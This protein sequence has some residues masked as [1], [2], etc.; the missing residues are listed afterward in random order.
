MSAAKPTA[1]DILPS[2]PL[3]PRLQF[4][5]IFLFIGTN[6]DILIVWLFANWRSEF[7]G[8]CLS[9]VVIAN[10]SQYPISGIPGDSDITFHCLE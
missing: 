9:S 8:N 1:V 3:T 6:W 7:I 10:N 5:R 4:T 2:I